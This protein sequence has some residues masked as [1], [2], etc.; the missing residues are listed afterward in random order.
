MSSEYGGDYSSFN[1][2]Y[3]GGRGRPDLG[4]RYYTRGDGGR[5]RGGGSPATSLSIRGDSGRGRGGVGPATS[6]S[7]PVDA[8]IKKGLDTSKAI[9]TIPPP[10]LPSG[11][12]DIP[13]ENVQYVSSYNWVDKE[14]PTIVV[15]GAAS[16]PLLPSRKISLTAVGFPAQCRFTGSVDQPRGPIHPA[17]RPG[18]PFHR[19]E[20]GTYVRV[21]LVS[22]L[23][24]RRRDTR[25]QQE[26]AGR[27]AF[28]GRRHGP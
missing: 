14:Q 2:G 9:E 21:P 15:P 22:P 19:P 23:R 1:R 12:E 20:R 28:R 27:L 6:L 13:I 16:P 4:N 26:S 3:G 7:F 18:L 17:A 11:V 10:S 24:R 8:D 5:G 25:K